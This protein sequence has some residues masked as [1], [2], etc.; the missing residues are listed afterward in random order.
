MGKSNWTT[1]LLLRWSNHSF[2]TNAKTH[3]FSFWP[4]N[5][6]MKKLITVITRHRYV[7]LKVVWN[8]YKDFKY[9]TVYPE[10]ISL[11]LCIQ[12][13]IH[14]TRYLCHISSVYDCFKIFRTSLV[15]DKFVTSW[16]QAFFDRT[17]E[18]VEVIVFPSLSRLLISIY[19]KVLPR[20]FKTLIFLSF[21]VSMVQL[22]FEVFALPWLIS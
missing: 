16:A 7:V 14:C 11:L 8:R 6:R 15:Y 4:T 5:N 22:I 2:S 1:S 20:K 9:Q 17:T 13:N 3:E 19:F 21:I 18:L 10:T 12:N